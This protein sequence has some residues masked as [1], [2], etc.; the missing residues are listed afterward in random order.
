MRIRAY[1]RL[2]DCTTNDRRAFVS[3]TQERHGVAAGKIAYYA[4][5]GSSWSGI[6]HTLNVFE[7][8]GYS[9]LD[10]NN[11]QAWTQDIGPAVP[12]LTRLYADQIPIA[13]F[14]DQAKDKQYAPFLT[15][16]E[17]D[18]IEA[19]FSRSRNVFAETGEVI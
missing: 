3:R 13:A 1:I 11:V 19:D 7:V 15:S 14:F 16:F 4:V 12:K 2:Q 18:A 8:V 6:R 17:P 10:K 5:E 9:N